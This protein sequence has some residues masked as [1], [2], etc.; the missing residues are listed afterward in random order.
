MTHQ[1]MVNRVATDGWKMGAVVITDSV[2]LGS[3]A[4]EVCDHIRQGQFVQ[5]MNKYSCPLCPWRSFQSP[6]RVKEHLSKYHVAKNQ[7]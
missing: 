7:Y 1:M 6:S 2:L 5:V 3:L 4:K